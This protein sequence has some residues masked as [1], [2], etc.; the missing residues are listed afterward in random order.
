MGMAMRLTMVV[1]VAVRMIVGM[2]LRHSG[3]EPCMAKKA[4]ENK[5][6]KAPFPPIYVTL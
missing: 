4:N 5:A 3:P 6:P 1:V 2:R